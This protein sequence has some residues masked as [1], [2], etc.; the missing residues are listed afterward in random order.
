MLAANQN[1]LAWQV[2]M[3]ELVRIRLSSQRAKLGQR[4]QARSIKIFLRS[5]LALKP[6]GAAWRS[7]RHVL[8]MIADHD[9]HNFDQCAACMQA[10]L[11]RQSSR[12][13]G[14]RLNFFSICIR[15]ASEPAWHDYFPRVLLFG[16]VTLQLC[17]EARSR[18][19][20][21]IQRTHT[22]E[23]SQTEIVSSHNNCCT[24]Q[25]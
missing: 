3:F 23:T 25:N 13:P 5:R 19:S 2:V 24:N 16:D 12:G 18:D 7:H 6:A 14:T 15:N 20:I 11:S 17:S 21:K 9:Q 10:I 4:S 22:S 8:V 1:A